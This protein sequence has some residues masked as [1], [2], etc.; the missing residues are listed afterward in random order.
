MGIGEDMLPQMID[1]TEVAGNTMKDV[2]LGSDLKEGVPVYVGCNDFFAGLLGMGMLRA[3]K[4]FDITGTSEHLGVITDWQP[5]L[6][7]TLVHGP[8]FQHYALYGVTASSGASLDFGRSL[9]DLN[10]ESLFSCIEKNPPIFMPYLNGERAPIWDVRA[11][12]GFL[13]ITQETT[14]KEL[15]YAV[16]EGVAF[17]LYHIYENMGCPE[18]EFI[19]VAGG[20]AKNKVLCEIKATLFNLPVATLCESDTSAMGAQMLAAIGN[21]AYANLDEAIKNNCIQKMRILPNKTRVKK[22]R[23]RFEIYKGLY[24][25][26]KDSFHMFHESMR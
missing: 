26:L 2:V 15:A 5:D 24:P 8:Y 25:A 18:A 9:Y 6:Q 4:M 21:G 7:T 20:A 12:G 14:A 17:S 13:G 19:T 10:D 22:L 23:E 3:G 1:F 16:M 11:S